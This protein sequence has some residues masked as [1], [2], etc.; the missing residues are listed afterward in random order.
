[1]MGVAHLHGKV[2][3]KPNILSDYNKGMAGIDRSNQMLSYY[4]A[5]RKTIRW[6]KPCFASH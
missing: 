2:M 1:M 4:S 6:Y 3:F 5:L